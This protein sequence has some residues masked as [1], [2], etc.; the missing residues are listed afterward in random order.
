[1]GTRRRIAV[2]VRSCGICTQELPAVDF[3]RR[4]GQPQTD[5]VQLSCK[6]LFHSFCIRGARPA[7]NP[8]P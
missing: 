1:M 6:H 5:V 2:S 8:K 7:L 3:Q 4:P